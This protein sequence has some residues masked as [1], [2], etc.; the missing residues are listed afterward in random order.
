MPKGKYKKADM[1]NGQRIETA[2]QIYEQQPECYRNKP[3]DDLWR[4]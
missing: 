2:N 3:N 1:R 4:A